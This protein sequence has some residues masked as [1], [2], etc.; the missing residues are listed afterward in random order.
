MQVLHETND[1]I[2]ES[3]DAAKDAIKKKVKRLSIENREEDSS[4]VVSK[5]DDVSISSDRAG[6]TAVELTECGLSEINGKYHQ[7]GSSDGVPAYSKI[8]SYKG[9][10]AIF[11]IGR[12]KSES[13]LKKWCITATVPDGS[14]P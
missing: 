11:T 13:G 7:F 10:E 5:P 1:E 4:S 14:S 6:C 2:S 9:K 12:W 3:V 8:D